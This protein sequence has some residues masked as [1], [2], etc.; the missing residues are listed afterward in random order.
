MR[1]HDTTYAERRHRVAAI[2]LFGAQFG[3][4]ACG[5]VAP[6]TPPES[7]LTRHAPPRDAAAVPSVAPASAPN[8]DSSATPNVEALPAGIEP[9]AV[10]R[11]ALPDYRAA[12]VIHGNA[13]T[14]RALVYLHGIC[15]N[16]DKIR[17]WAPAIADAVTTIAV[18]GNKECP[19]STTRFSWNQD[20]EFMHGLIQ[21]ALTRVA[22][23]RAGQLDVQQ[24]VLF[25]YSQGASRAERLV[26]RYPEH[27][28]WLILGGPP[29]PPEFAHLA[30]ARRSAL[31][32]GSEEHQEH[33][34]EVATQL[35]TQGA[36]TRFDT[37]AGAGHGGFGPS[38]P[39]VMS[40]T[41]SWLLGP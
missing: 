3:A 18:F 41:L 9:G 24:V 10:V 12:F 14:R 36:P 8:A 27:Y 1:R 6:A 38:S 26:E 20:V 32:V 39:V 4:F 35:T 31:L 17:D 25:G 22:E 23:A 13:G 28:P 7:R 30:G 29:R 16:V 2:V 37:F 21:L 5:P 15:G 40:R 11:V 19:T 33:L 34:A